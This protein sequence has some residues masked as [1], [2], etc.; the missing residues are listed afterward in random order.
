MQ[1]SFKNCRNNHLFGIKLKKDVF[2]VTN[3]YIFFFKKEKVSKFIK[4]WVL[5]IIFYYFFMFLMF[6]I[7]IKLSQ[8]KNIYLLIHLNENNN[9]KKEVN[10]KPL[11]SQNS[12]LYKQWGTTVKR[13]Y[14]I[15]SHIIISS[16]HIQI[17]LNSV[18]L[19]YFFWRTNYYTNIKY[20]SQNLKKTIGIKFVVLLTY[21]IYI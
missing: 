20:I 6:I 12:S 2:K 10:T 8:L 14:W 21:H 3:T 4:L 11:S 19:K 16:W 15:D 1:Y 5:L 13:I 18:S 7:F 9:I 17:I